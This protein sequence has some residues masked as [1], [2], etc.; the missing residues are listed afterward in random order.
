MVQVD[1][2]EESMLDL[3]LACK[4][5]SIKEFLTSLIIIFK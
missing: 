4:K 2:I 1:V 3:N 5:Q